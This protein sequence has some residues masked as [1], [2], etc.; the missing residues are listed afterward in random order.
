MAN[1]QL[2][3]KKNLTVSRTN[4]SSNKERKVQDMRD[5]NIVYEPLVDNIHARRR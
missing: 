2:K 1:G 3:K 5:K 4:D